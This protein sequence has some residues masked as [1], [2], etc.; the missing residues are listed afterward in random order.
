MSTLLAY[1][2][3]LIAYL[4]SFY[5]YIPLYWLLFLGYPLVYGA[6]FALSRLISSLSRRQEPVE[7]S[8]YTAWGIAFLVHF[9]AFLVW[10]LESMILSW[11]GPF[12]R[13]FIFAT[14]MGIL[15]ACVRLVPYVLM[16]AFDVYF[17]YKL[18]WRRRHGRA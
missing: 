3:A 9:F 8:V 15:L 17:A 18:L 1:G 2:T 5:W 14:G 13:G 16:G 11:Y 10:G 12:G 4:Q 7:R 6:A